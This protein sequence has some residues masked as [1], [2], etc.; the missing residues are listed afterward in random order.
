M[1]LRRLLCYFIYAINFSFFREAH[2]TPLTYGSTVYFIHSNTKCNLFTAKIT[3]SN[4]NQA[5]TCSKEPSS[6]N[7]WYLRESEL[8]YKGAGSAILCGDT[9]RIQSTHSD[10]FIEGS[11]SNVKSMIS[12]QYEVSCK[13]ESDC[14]NSK[15]TIECIRK[16]SGEKLEIRDKFRLL[17]TEMKGYLR[18]SKRNL[19]DNSNCPRCPI[20]GHYEVAITLNSRKSEDDI[21][22]FKQGLLIEN[23]MESSD[24]LKDEL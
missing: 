24:K 9:I 15:F 8:P 23:L 19:F 7:M 3:W 18:S 6:E 5:V 13:D 17:N 21:W 20:V 12:R 2:A 22:E 16:K 4:G 10:R 11:G 1:T 14:I